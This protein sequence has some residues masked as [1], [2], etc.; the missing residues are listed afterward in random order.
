VVSDGNGVATVFIQANL[1]AP[2]QPATLRATELTTGNQVNGQFT[3]VQPAA[4]S[5]TPNDA[6]ITAPDNTGCLIGFRVDYRV[7]G[8]TPPYSAS[9]SVPNAVTLLNAVNIQFGGAFSAITTGICANPV[10]LTVVDATGQTTTATLH[11]L[12][13]STAPPGP[14]PTVFVVPG[15]IDATKTG[16]CGA[17]TATFSFVFG[18]GTPPYN[19]SAKGAFTVA[20]P[21]PTITPQVLAAPGGVLITGL[22][23]GLGSAKLAEYDFEVVD[24]SGGSAPFSVQ[25]NP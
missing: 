19:I 22:F 11:N 23:D 24:A 4:L 8:G 6:T 3:I 18:S 16:G 7:F 2:T 20:K 14:A 1:G 17:G 5:V 21:V 12:L 9:S 15:S 25:C 13:G 10:T